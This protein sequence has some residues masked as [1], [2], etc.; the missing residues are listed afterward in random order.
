MVLQ[1]ISH[2]PRCGLNNLSTE[3]SREHS[4]MNRGKPRLQSAG[5]FSACSENGRRRTIGMHMSVGRR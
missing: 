3:Y 5:E 4:L 1:S 2:T